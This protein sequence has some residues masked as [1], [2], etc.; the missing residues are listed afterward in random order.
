MS[1]LISLITTLLIFIPFAVVAYDRPQCDVLFPPLEPIHVNGTYNPSSENYKCYDGT[2]TPATEITCEASTFIETN[3]VIPADV[4][5]DVGNFDTKLTKSLDGGKTY[6]F[7][8]WE[9]KDHKITVSGTGTAVVYIRKDGDITIKKKA[10]INKSGDPSQLMIIMEITNGNFKLLEGNSPSKLAPVNAYFYIASKDGDNVFEENIALAGHLTVE[11]GLQIKK[12]GTYTYFPLTGVDTGGFC[13][14]PSAVHH[15]KIEH[16]GTGATCNAE[17]VTISACADATCSSLATEEVVLDVQGNSSTIST[18]TFTGSSTFSFNHTTAETLSLSITNSSITPDDPT[19]VCDDGSTN[20]CDIVFDDTGCP[21][22]P[23]CAAAENGIY[24]EAE[25]QIG[26]GVTINGNSISSGDT[27]DNGI[28]STGTIENPSI[29]LTSLG[30]VTFGTT[31]TTLNDG[32]A[33]T[34]GSYKNVVVSEDANITMA[35]GD[36][37]IDYLDVLKRATVTLLGPVTIHV[38]KFDIEDDV[39]MNGPYSNT[40]PV[41]TSGDASDL[42]VKWYGGGTADNK[43]HIHKR[44]KFTGV[45]YS[46]GVGGTE[47]VKFHDDVKFFGGIYTDNIIK[48]GN[49][50][51]FTYTITEQI[52]AA[53]ILNCDVGVI[54][55]FEI[56]H[57]SS[58]STCVAESVTIKACATADCSSLSADSVTVDFQGNSSTISSQTFTGSTTFTFDHITAETLTLSLANESITPVDSNEICDD[59]SA[60]SC[61]IIFD[62]SNCSNCLAATN[63]IYGEAELQIGTGVTINGNSITSGDTTDNSITSSGATDNPNINLTSLGSVTFG[64][65][66]VTWNDGSYTAGSYKTVFVPEDAVITMAAGDYYVD[67]FDVSKR[68]IITLLGPVTIHVGKFDLADDVEMNGPYSNT[69]PVTSSGDA[70]DLVINW[71]GGGTE[72]NKFH[73]HKRVKFTGLIYSPGIVHSEGVKFHD[74]AK[75]FGGIYTDNIIKTA[76]NTEFTFGST[77]QTA[78]GELF[79]CNIG[80][81]DHYQII[82]DGAGLTCEAEI[83]TIK[84]CTNAFDGSCTPSTDAG[85]YTLKAVGSSNTVTEAGTFTNG[86]GTVNL[87]Y[88][89]VETVTLSL[90]GMSPAATNGYV[91]NDDSADSCNLTFADAEFRFLYGSG[92]SETIANQISGNTFTDTL[93]LQAVQN[94]NGVCEDL[95]INSIDVNLAQENVT[96]SGTDGLSF[97]IN[98]NDNISK[99]PTYTP[100]VSLNFGADSIATIP[101]PKYLD[102]GEIRLRASYSDA[103]IS[104]I[105]SSQSFWV[106]PDHFVISAKSGGNDIDGSNASTATT[107]K[108]GAPFDLVVT[109]E[110]S[111]NNTTQNYQQGQMQLK[112]TRV[113]PTSTGSVEG[114]LNY[115]S[116][117]TIT[118]ATS[119]IFANNA[120]TSFSLGTSEFSVA[121]ID[122]VGIFSLDVQDLNYGGQGLVIEASEINIGRFIPA[123]F[124]LTAQDV[125]NGC[126]DFTYMEQPNL[127]LTYKIEPQNTSNIK[128]QNY[129]ASFIHS[130]VNFV[131]EN[132]DNATDLV[133][134][135]ADYSSHWSSASYVPADGNI[136]NEDV[137]NFSRDSMVDGPFASLIVGIALDD[138]EVDGAKLEGL[139]M[140]ADTTGVC[141]TN[142][143]GSTDLT[144]CTAK[145][146][147]LT[148]SQIRFGRWN[149]E[150]AYGPESESMPVAMTVQQWDGSN[151]ITNVDEN[152]ITP[153]ITSKET[154]GAIWSGGLT[155]WQYRLVDSDGSDSLGVANTSASLSGTIVNGEFNTPPNQFIFSAPNNSEQGPLQFEYQVPTWLQYDWEDDGSFDENPTGLISFGLFRGNDR[156]ISWREVG[157]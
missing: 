120:L 77:E 93:R 41:T 99:Y 115:A 85:S 28:D 116:G 111:Q 98:T 33:F 139:D 91:C 57:D 81:I 137:G 79:N 69:S 123:K 94:V 2:S 20:N 74:D 51:E 86:V 130:T 110:N 96:P 140:R 82:H 27:T 144:D 47:G 153:S 133:G 61:D 103:G 128:T 118:S 157:N 126:N 143:D 67:Y 5:C 42:T 154:S 8:D 146:L 134:R 17:S 1:K 39:E 155:D 132:S 70:G 13:E 100:D 117:Q 131:A 88:T 44:A 152:C 104:L 112:F 84:A 129:L 71:Y 16:D 62:D 55:H 114:V 50:S 18:Q 30:S 6:C 108:T 12:N 36:Y 15:F 136:F 141:T 95:F 124:V 22:P 40:S 37:Y 83:V 87:S 156:I 142:Y 35:A 58:G 149:I 65:T 11:E 60:N 19:L 78:A 53:A 150:N 14:V 122:E 73:I 90:E 29:S 66:D 125:E 54:D 21:D 127:T 32:D 92:T 89:D 43:F 121:S 145:A 25:L 147:S 68:A 38:G 107:H 113:L 31:D 63:G 48:T 10:E 80:G 23:D 52:A 34:A 45:I 151:F 64:S 135:L 49:N 109:A 56:I 102:A 97:Q 59:G 24:G 72:D 105:G 9:E 138:G 119:A 4:V 76:N 7:N 26:T 106:K 3:P 75:F 148:A 46:T 101:T